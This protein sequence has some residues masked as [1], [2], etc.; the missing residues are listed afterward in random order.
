MEEEIITKKNFEKYFEKNNIID[1]S[2]YKF[3]LRMEENKK[4]YDKIEIENYHF[5]ITSVQK[6]LEMI[7]NDKKK[8]H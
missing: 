4:A 5:F 6:R 1:I 7:R 2:D 8:K 3:Y